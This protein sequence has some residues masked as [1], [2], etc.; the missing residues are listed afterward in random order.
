MAYEFYEL[1]NPKG[2]NLAYWVKNAKVVG[3]FIRANAI[4][5]ATIGVLGAREG[6]AEKALPPNLGIKGGIRVP[7]LHFNEQ[8]YLLNEEQWAKF[9]RGIIAS[10]KARLVQA[11]TVSFEEGMVL[12]SM[13]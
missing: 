12:G 5:A 8:I 9:S 2:G 6:P 10:A 1:I 7:H 3:E 11:K 4:P 13:V